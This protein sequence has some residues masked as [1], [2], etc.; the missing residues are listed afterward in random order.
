MRQLIDVLAAAH[1]IGEMHFPIVAIV[2][3]GQRGRDSALGHHGVR[4]A[5]QT[6]ANHADRNA[7]GRSFNGRAQPG[8]AGADDQNVVR[9]SFVV[10]MVR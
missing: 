2:D 9:E 8:A 7:G 5:E 3:I 6:F 10:G 1:G 4:F